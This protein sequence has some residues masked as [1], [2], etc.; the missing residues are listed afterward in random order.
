MTQRFLGSTTG[1]VT[2][3]NSSAVTGLLLAMSLLP[4]AI[5]SFPKTTHGISIDYQTPG[6][7]KV[8]LRSEMD[9]SQSVAHVLQRLVKYFSEQEPE[10]SPEIASIGRKHFREMYVRF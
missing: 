7:L 6:Q 1:G 5:Y 3:N 8:K 10:I 9:S 2:L 4:A